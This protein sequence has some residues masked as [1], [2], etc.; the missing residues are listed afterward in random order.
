MQARAQWL[1][2]VEALADAAAAPVLVDALFGTGLSRRLDDALAARLF[3]LRGK[4]HLSIAVDLPSGVDTD[5]GAVLSDRLVQH[6]VTLALGAL[7]PAHVLAPSAGYCGTVRVLDIGVD[8]SRDGDVMVIDRPRLQSPGYDST[9]YTRGM[10]AVIGGSMPGAA[11]LAS[12]AA[13][14]AGAGYVLLL[15]DELPWG[16]P[17]ALVRKSWS[18]DALREPRIGCVLVGP[19]LG[20]DDAARA[21]LDAAI[22]SDRPLVIDGDA[23]HLLDGR[24]F[25]DRAAPTILTPHGGE[26]VKVFG[27]WHGSKIDAA[28][29]AASTSG[30]VVVFKGADTVIA[31]PSGRTVVSPNGSSWLSTAGTGDVLAGAVAAMAAASD[32]HADSAAAVWMHGE[33]ARRLGGAFVADDLARELSAVRASL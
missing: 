12:E 3:A 9:K 20:R 13:M 2:P 4:A 10:V 8:V 27:E 26:F 29:T 22:A 15:A 21:K 7:K 24:T 11:A 25:H 19:G 30:A 33:A 18:A 31:D 28:R 32:D 1:G 16:S 5:A 23:L 17:H 14:R 6:D